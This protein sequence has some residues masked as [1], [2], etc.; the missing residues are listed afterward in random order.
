MFD[1]FF[2]IWFHRGDAAIYKRIV[3]QRSCLALIVLFC[4]TN[5]PWSDEFKKYQWM[6][7]LF[8]FLKLGGTQCVKKIRAKS[9]RS[10]PVT[11][12]SPIY[13]L[14]WQ[15]TVFCTDFTFSEFSITEFWFLKHMS[16]SRLMLLIRS[17]IIIFK[18]QRQM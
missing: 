12:F 6:V 10:E 3:M 8:P 18:F 2:C 15:L 14:L 4:R 13:F 5:W 7:K 1:I 17:K 11:P 9:K 16:V